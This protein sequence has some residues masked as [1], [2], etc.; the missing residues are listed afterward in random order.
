M[1]THNINHPRKHMDQHRHQDRHH[2][3]QQDGNSSAGIATPVVLATTGGTSASGKNQCTRTKLPF[4]TKKVAQ[5][6]IA[7]QQ[8]D[9]GGRM[10]YITQNLK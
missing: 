7:E 2:P 1:D 9:G 6:K 4:E 8:P 3:N 10:T 5:Q